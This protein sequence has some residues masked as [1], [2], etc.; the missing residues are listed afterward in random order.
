MYQVSLNDAYFPAQSDGK[1]DNLSV[2]EALRI[3]AKHFTNNIAVVDVDRKGNLGQS[4]TYIELL[5]HSEAL[6]LALST[7]Y[8]PGERVV[9]WAPNSLQWLLMEYACALAGLVLVTA[10]PSFQT[11]ELRY[12]VEQSGAAGLFLVNEFRGNPMM[13]IANHAVSG[14]SLMREIINLEDK[15]QLFR[16]GDFSEQLPYVDPNS[17]AQ[18]QYTSG[19]TGFPKG[20]VLSHRSL[21]NNARLFAMRKGVHQN[22]VWANFMPMFHTA[23]CATA[24]LGC[25]QT[26]CK[27]LLIKHFDAL[28]LARLIE[29]EQV[30]T[31]FAVPTMLVGLLESLDKQPNDMSSMESITTG[32]APVP[33]ELVR[34]V[35]DRLQCHL[36]TAFGQ[37]EHAPMISLN[38]NDVS[39]DDICLRAGQPLPFTEVSIRDPQTNNVKAVNTVGEICARSYA[40]MLGYHEN[41]A[42]THSAIDNE[43]WLHTGDLGML[44]ER[45]FITVTGRVKDMII[46]GGEN[47]FPAE[48][49]AVLLEQSSIAEVSVVGLPDKKWGEV[50]GAFV[51]PAT[52][53]LLDVK[54]LR[55]HC[56]KHLSAQKTPNIWVQVNDF[57]KTG[58]GKIQKFEI[59]D[60][61][62]S[63]GYG[64]RLK[65]VT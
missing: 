7:R 60:S 50:I 48:I 58:S 34:N 46:R 42:A 54:E 51:R 1:L 20:A 25:L 35:K 24:A 32:G 19:T 4:M 5:S 33:A 27:M 14:N 64:E 53:A 40:I 43:G 3:S 31:F 56:R 44:D 29:Q 13:Q 63:G 15:K 11:K 28:L 2:G 57:P 23:G 61:Y 10:N 39:L 47:H 22:S 49:E 45:G 52:G 8:R 6:S 37:T 12:V 59:R 18:I 21:L 17:A 16:K 41:D 65:D 55:R 30:T 36:Q 62:L 26:G 9:V 38:H